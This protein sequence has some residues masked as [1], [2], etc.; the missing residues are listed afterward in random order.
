M[1]GW[2]VLEVTKWA[3]LV[4]LT[5]GMVLLAQLRQDTTRHGPVSPGLFSPLGMTRHSTVR[6]IK[7]G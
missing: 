6:P 4:G 2:V 3:V 5:Q 7:H 1:D